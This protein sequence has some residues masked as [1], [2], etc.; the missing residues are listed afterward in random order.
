MKQLHLL[1]VGASTKRCPKCQ[2]VKEASG[3]AKREPGRHSPSSYCKPCQST[4]S[5]AH[6][7]RNKEEHNLRRAEHQREYRSR[8]REYLASVLAHAFCVDCGE[9]D[10]IVLE[11]DH[12]TSTK[13]FDVSRM[14]YIGRSIASI[15]A[16]I[17]KCVIRCA[18]CHRRKTATSL[19]KGSPRLGA[20]ADLVGR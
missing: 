4:Y 7:E 1:R 5:R 16:E 20:K 8:N 2:V 17:A 19:W 14:I 9:S 15:D 10:P 13:R 11:F 3:F 6:Y 12:V 18:N